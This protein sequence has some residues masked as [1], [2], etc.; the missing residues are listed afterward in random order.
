MP[1]FSVLHTLLREVLTRHQAGRIPEPDLVM[2]DPD[3]VAAYTRAGLEDG[4]M[5][6]VYLY[7]CAQICDVIRPDDLVLDLACGPATQ[8]GMAARLNPAT[9]FIGIDMSGPMLARA[10][11]HV[12]Q[13]GLRNVSFRQ[14]DICHLDMFDDHSM[15]AVI[16]TLALHH[17]PT[18][19]HLNQTLA[20]V[21]RVLK[22]GGG[23]YLLDFGRL[24]SERSMLYF[25]RQHADKQ[26]EL[27]TQDYLDS[28]RAAFSLDQFH[29]AAQALRGHARLYSTFIVPFMVAI[30]SP[31]RRGSDP[32]L[33]AQLK[34][35]KD[36]LPAFQRAD[37]SQLEQFFRWGGLANPL[38]P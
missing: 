18:A 34:S 35:I 22:P 11:D 31:S 28:L 1:S 5:A 21:G 10:E 9:R 8:L 27:F 20:E 17:L 24:K 37:L 33:L 30:K 19:E 38:L 6:A 36:A 12:A 3:K 13:Q 15:D 7:N 14:G 26:P 32:A 16:S 29:S 2:D 23:L 4:V 25:S